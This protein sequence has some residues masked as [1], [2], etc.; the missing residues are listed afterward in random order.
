MARYA[1]RYFFDPGSGICLWAGCD[2]ARARFGYPVQARQ[3]P[4][5]RETRERVAALVD[6]YDRSVD[7]EYPAGPSL[8]DEAEHARFAAAASRL[9]AVLRAELGA[10][11]EIRDEFA[12]T[13]PP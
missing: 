13:L 2:A 10:D 5:T 3:L 9:L 7:W 4:L 11:F 6:W 12:A 1:L 8:W